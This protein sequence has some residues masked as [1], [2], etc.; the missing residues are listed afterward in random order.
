[1]HIFPNPGTGL[2]QITLPDAPETQSVQVQ[3]ADLTGRIMWSNRIMADDN[4]LSVDARSLPDGVYFCKVRAA[5]REYLP[6][7]MVI[8]R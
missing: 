5:Q 4:T 3:F 6:V 8:N 7:K 2:L 1:M